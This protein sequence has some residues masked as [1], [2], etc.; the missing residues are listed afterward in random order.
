MDSH[1]G[2]ERLCPIN[3]F[4]VLGASM[5]EVYEA[6]QQEVGVASQP[7]IIEDTDEGM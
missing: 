1:Y 2:L 7:S 6:S 5:I 3:T 4:K